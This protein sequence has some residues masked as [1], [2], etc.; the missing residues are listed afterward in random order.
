MRAII[1]KLELTHNLSDEEFMALY[2][3]YDNLGD[4]D[5]EF[6]DTENRIMEIVATY[7]D[8]HITDFAE[9]KKD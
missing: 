4:L 6:L 2:E 9:V 5:D 8:E 7:V 3:Q 1:D